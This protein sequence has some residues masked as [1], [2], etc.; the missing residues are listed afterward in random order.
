MRKFLIVAASLLFLICAG[1]G[2]AKF[3]LTITDT[4]EV[5]RKWQF[6]GTAP[7]TQ[8]IEE[9]KNKNEKL[10]PN[11]KIDTVV[12]GDMHGY[13]FT[14]RH[15]N[16]ES[17]A[18]STSEIYRGYEGSPTCISWR[19]NW[20]FDEY[21]FD[22]VAENEKPSI[23]LGTMVNET[24]FSQVVY[25]VTINLP[26]AADETDADKILDGGKVLVWNLA[27][28]LIYGGEKSM[29]VRFKIWHKEEVAVTAT[30]EL[31]LL[32]A[33]IFFLI[34][35][36]SEE[37]ESKSRDLRFKRNVFACLFIALSSI[38]AYLIIA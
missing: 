34:K 22:F 17:F 38:S 31:L 11:I 27:P 21:E 19:R 32:I 14:L 8:Q 6:I 30:I 20:F 35:A 24:L 1:C 23:P 4:G 10:F 13:E 26:Y 9:V 28:I 5:I 25:D 37:S 2:Q 29:Q 3:D 15:P 33:T 7:F 12:E 16:I 18:Q 36:R